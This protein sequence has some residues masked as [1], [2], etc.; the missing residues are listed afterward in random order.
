MKVESQAAT[1]KA[2]KEKERTQRE[3]EEQRNTT[4]HRAE[5]KLAET[6]E[7]LA[8]ERQAREAAEARARDA[9]EKLARMEGV[10]QE[11]R[12]LVITLN[13]AVLF[14]SGR[15]TLSPEGENKLAQVA[16]NLKLMQA[17]RSIVVE[18]HT[19]A[20]GP[21]EA[22]EELSLKR[23]DAVRNYLVQRG[24]PA[25]AG[26]NRRPWASRVRSP[27]TERRKVARRIVASKSSSSPLRSERL[28]VIRPL[29]D[30]LP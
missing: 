23:A 20:M 21:P 22:N 29:G 5:G 27:T 4:L 7:A 25:R 1:A 26:P 12:G 30:V 16:E 10:T 17:N 14:G 9:A 28:G 24:I 3:M 19:D 15:R 8:Q 11:T 2:T 6:R 18:G 13:G